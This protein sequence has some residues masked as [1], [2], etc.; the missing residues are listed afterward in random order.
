VNRP[1]GAFNVTVN[2]KGA[3]PKKA[4]QKILV[5]LTEKGE[6]TQKLY[7]KLG[8]FQR[9]DG[10]I[11][12]STRLNPGKTTFFIPNQVNMEAVL[13]DKLA[14]LKAEYKMIDDENNLRVND[15]RSASNGT[16]FTFSD[17]IHVYTYP[18]C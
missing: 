16:Q 8:L 17:N 11:Y 5:A 4:T 6:L 12:Y 14:A 2:L 9:E 13:F 7:G 1:F 18:I 3:V 15:I 10:H